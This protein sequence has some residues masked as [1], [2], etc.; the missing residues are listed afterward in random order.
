MAVASSSVH[1]QIHAVY[2]SNIQWC[3]DFVIAIQTHNNQA[4]KRVE[5]GGLRIFHSELLEW[6]L[7]QLL[8]GDYFLFTHLPSLSF[9]MSGF[10]GDHFTKTWHLS[11]INNITEINK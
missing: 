2:H 3:I 9:N 11:C 7:I 4:H 8:A 1:T 6:L 5:S 10:L